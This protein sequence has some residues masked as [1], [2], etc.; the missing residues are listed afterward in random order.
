MKIWVAR[1][2]QE[3]VLR[4]KCRGYRFQAVALLFVERLFSDERIP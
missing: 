3:D 4:E 2:D 1:I